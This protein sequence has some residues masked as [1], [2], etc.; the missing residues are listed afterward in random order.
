MNFRYAER[1]LLVALDRWVREGV[2]PPESRYG[3]VSDG[4]L[5]DAARLKISHYSRF[6]KPQT[7]AETFAIELG[8]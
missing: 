4:S 7:H 6:A 2:A 3:R 8:E 1:A 5:V